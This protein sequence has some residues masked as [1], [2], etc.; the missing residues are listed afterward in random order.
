MTRARRSSDPDGLPEVAVTRHYLD[1]ASTSPPRPEVI[2][3]M[4]GWLESAAAAD[5]GRVHTEGRIAREELEG[6]RSVVAELLGTRPR[7]VVFTSSG[8]EAVNTAVWGACRA[9]PTGAVILADVEHSSVRD[10]SMRLTDVDHIPVDAM[11][12]IDSG[13][14]VEALDRHSASGRPV[15]LVHCQFANHE[16]ATLQPVS[17]IVAICRSRG[18]PV[19]VDACT[20][21]G[22]VPLA[23]DELGADLVSV[24]AHKLG[25]PPGIGALVVR[26]GLRFEPLHLGGEQERARRGGLENLPAAAGFAAV[27]AALLHS[28]RLA[29]EA[30]E[31]RRHTQRLLAGACGVEGVHALGDVEHRVPHVVC[32]AVD[33]VEAEP[34]LLAL[35]QAGIAAHSGSSCSSESL[36]PSSVLEAMGADAERSLRLSVGWSTTDADVDA[37][38]E[39]FPRAVGRLRALRP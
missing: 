14:V 36:A 24:S 33:G 3:A 35:D 27:A 13:A 15:A 26:R 25:G 7:Q 21:A 39:A 34:V 5:P 37:F 10:A 17:E 2:A 38:I 12:R 19:H 32:L 23:L 31:A 11:A 16:V 6:S 22:H 20:A 29:A 8:T 4:V 9:R 30:T 18:V 1:H 28:G